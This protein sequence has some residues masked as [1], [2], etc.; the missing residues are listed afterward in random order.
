MDKATVDGEKVPKR[1]KKRGSGIGQRKKKLRK[2][3]YSK[4]E[5]AARA[6]AQA[7]RD[8]K[9]EKKEIVSPSVQLPSPQAPLPSVE[10][11]NVASSNSRSRKIKVNYDEGEIT[12]APVFNEASRRIMIA[13]Y[14][15]YRHKMD[16]NK[17]NWHGK[18]GIISDIK[19]TFDI[20]RGT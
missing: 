17:D 9:L 12:E 16:S 19:K 14:F 10:N 20:P 7:R 18:G 1:R 8:A 4:A 11:A 6:A 15:V 2:R 13:G 3:S 5:L